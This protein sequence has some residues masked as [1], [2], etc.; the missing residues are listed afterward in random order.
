MFLLNVRLINNSRETG[1]DDE[2]TTDIYHHA[3]NNKKVNMGRLGE[4]CI[5]TSDQLI[6]NLLVQ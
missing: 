5:F 2:E 3:A 1:M 4:I 6:Q